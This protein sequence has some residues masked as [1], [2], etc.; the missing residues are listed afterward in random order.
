MTASVTEAWNFSMIL[1]NYIKPNERATG[2]SQVLDIL[3]K[4][5]KMDS[6]TSTHTTLL[7]VSCSA[8]YRVKSKGKLVYKV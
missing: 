8:P 1:K 6:R 7:N 3:I 5:F 4:T 2:R